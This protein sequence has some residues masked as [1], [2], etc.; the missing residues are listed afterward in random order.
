MVYPSQEGAERLGRTRAPAAVYEGTKQIREVRPVQAQYTYRQ[1]LSWF[2]NQLP[3]SELYSIPEATMT[4]VSESLNRIEVGIDCEANR[5]SV[6]QRL[7]SLLSGS[8]IPIEAIKVTVYPREFFPEYPDDF[9]C[10]PPEVVDP[11]TGSSSPGFGGLFVDDDSHAIDDS[12][13]INVY[14]LEPSQSVAEELALAVIGKDEFERYAGV[15]AL[16]GEYTWEQ[17]LGWHQAIQESGADILG[18]NLP[19]VFPDPFRN[20]ITV[21]VDPDL[22]ANVVS[23]LKTLLAQIQV[24]TEVVYMQD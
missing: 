19:S 22:N 21:Q 4:A 24:P 7:P 6:N 12:H 3:R 8:H 16:Q 1:L 15:K 14:M 20:R 18:L 11:A 17:I 5:D 2:R 13:T 10:A 9:E 23:D